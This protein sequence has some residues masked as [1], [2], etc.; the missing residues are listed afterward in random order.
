MIKKLTTLFLAICFVFAGVSI[1]HAQEEESVRA[2]LTPASP[3]YFFEQ[4]FEDIGTVFTFSDARRAQRF[5]SLA[6]ERLAE[7]EATSETNT[8]ASERALARYQQQYEQAVRNAERAD[9]DT[10]ERVADATVRHLQTL[11]EVSE[12]VPEEAREAIARAKA[13]SVE[14]QLSA[15]EALSER[16]P[17]RGAR[18]F[19][20]VASRRADALQARGAETQEDREEIEQ[21]SEQYQEFGERISTLGQG[22]QTGDTSVEDIVREAVSHHTRVLEDVRQ[23]VPQQAQE[24][25]DRAMQESSDRVPDPGT[26]GSAEDDDGI[27]EAPSEFVPEDAQRVIDDIRQQVESIG[28]QR[29]QTSEDEETDDAGGPPEDTPGASN[30]P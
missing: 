2:G 16:N 9:E 11:D 29:G 20:D 28:S 6:E 22:L 12:R 4:L 30:R 27:S 25:I 19:A 10:Q 15:L 14:G 17:E 26:R 5:L 1:V 18:V 13:S 21:E 23:R 7:V 3:F 24:Q 8:A